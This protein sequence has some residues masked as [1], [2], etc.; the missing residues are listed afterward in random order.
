MITNSDETQP[1]QGEIWMIDFDPKH[2][3]EIGKERPAVVVNA[4]YVGRLPIRIVVPVTK[5]QASR[6]SYPWMIDIHPG[7]RN[8]LRMR[9]HAD[10]FQVKSLSTGRF[11]KKLGRINAEDLSEIHRAL[12]LCLGVTLLEGGE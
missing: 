3:S 2:G 12:A 9:S 8:G 10:C 1:Y 4:D 7:K 6:S 5:Y 11:L